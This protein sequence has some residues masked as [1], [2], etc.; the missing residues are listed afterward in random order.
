MSSRAI[1][2]VKGMNDALPGDAWRF[3]AL[4][5]VIRDVACL[6]GYRELRTPL[7]EPTPL[8][9]RS[10]GEGTDI[11][12]KEMYS[13]VF[14]DEPLTLRPEGTAG[15]VRAYIEHSIHATQPVSRF[16][17]EGPMFRG[18]RP[19]RGRYR[20][21]HQAGCEVFG[22]EG[23]VIDA[24]M[25]DMLVGLLRKLEISDIEVLVNSLG[26]AGTKQRYRERLVAHLTPLRD[27]LS[28]VSQKRL[29]QNPLRVLDSKHPKDQEAIASAPSILDAIDDDDKRHFDGVC[30]HLDRLAVPY[31]VDPR[32]VR[33]LDYYTRTLFELRGRG[34]ELGAQNALGGGGR[35]DNLVEELGGPKTPAIGFALG[36]ERLLLASTA[37][38]DA[39]H[40]PVVVAPVGD[41]AIGESLTFARELRS[42]GLATVVD[43]RGGSLKS[44]LKRA[45]GISASIAVIF[46]DEELDRGVVQVKDLAARSQ[47]D[48]P[49]ADAVSEIA[50]LRA[51]QVSSAIAGSVVPKDATLATEGARSV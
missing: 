21:F 30:R 32:L 26:G 45:N 12:D 44:M 18:E 27:S 10:V 34:G 6:H 46:G 38:A 17:Y 20:Q 3:R 51:R 1:A 40:G 2:A 35:Y 47:L 24:E 11:V 39:Q 37:I 8:F 19:A 49:R 29:L 7:V 5:A 43:G 9:V 23:P 4:E 33:G 50:A 25:I 13:F 36:L 41:R 14:H 42:I 22:D 31:R 48:V 28:E 16:Y 15:V